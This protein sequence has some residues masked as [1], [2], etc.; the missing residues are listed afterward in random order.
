MSNQNIETIDVQDID[1]S[2]IK[3]IHF[4]LRLLPID[5]FATVVLPVH[6]VSLNALP[7]PNIQFTMISTIE[8]KIVCNGALMGPVDLLYKGSETYNIECSKISIDPTHIS[9]DLSVLLVYTN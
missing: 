6:S 2:L 3:Q 1:W 5:E 8:A 4:N 9:D 7:V